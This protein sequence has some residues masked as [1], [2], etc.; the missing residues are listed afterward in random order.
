MGMRDPFAYPQ[1]S[2]TFFG[3]NQILWQKL[4]FDLNSTADQPLNQVVPFSDSI[5]PITTG[6]VLITRASTSMAAMAGTM[7][8]A[9]GTG[10]GGTVLVSAASLTSLTATGVVL[11]PSLASSSRRGDGTLYAKLSSAFGSAA[12]CDVF[13]IGIPLS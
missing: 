10:G 8:I 2:A 6:T 9:T 4:N 1:N 5:F 11:R 3:Q 13:V 12:T 7:T